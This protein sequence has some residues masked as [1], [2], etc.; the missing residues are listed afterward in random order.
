MC[1]NGT[2]FE[3]FSYLLDFEVPNTAQ[4][5]WGI[6]KAVLAKLMPLGYLLKKTWN[7]AR[8]NISEPLDGSVELSEAEKQ[9]PN[10]LDYGLLTRTIHCPMFWQYG[11][12]VG[13]MHSI[14]DSLASWGEG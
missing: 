7:L 9:E 1:L 13:R 2:A 11:K 12:M 4:W 10:S 6:I 14:P 3:H 5:R 8:H